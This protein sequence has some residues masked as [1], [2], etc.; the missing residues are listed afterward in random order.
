M[1][2]WSRHQEAWPRSL[3]EVIRN[4]QHGQLRLVWPEELRA[5]ARTIPETDEIDVYLGN[6]RAIYFAAHYGPH[7]FERIHLVGE[8]LR[9]GIGW[10]VSSPVLAIDLGR[11]L[12][13]TRSGAIY[14]LYGKR[15]TG[16][17]PAHQI[18]LLNQ[19]LWAWGH[20]VGL[21]AIRGPL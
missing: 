3:G 18:Y 10:K 5:L 16:E 7:R 14:S 19:A 13:M 1:V 8:N 21:G 6:W 17:P 9:R 20:G 11:S 2:N 15:G 12:A 4:P